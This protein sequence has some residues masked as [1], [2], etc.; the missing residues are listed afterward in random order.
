MNKIK[1][2]IFIFFLFASS[3][4]FSQSG[5]TVFNDT[6]LHEIRIQF[7]YS[8]WFDSLQAD[9]QLNLNDTSDEFSNRE[10]LCSM[11]FDNILLDSIGMR[12]RGNFSNFSAPLTSSNGLKKPF[13]LI[14][15]AFQTQKFD[16]LKELNLN[17]GTDDPSFV[18]EALVY[19]LVRDRGLP[20]CRTGYAKLFVNDV[21]WGLYELVENVDKTFLKDHY[22]DA[23]NDGNLYKTDRNAGVDL[24]WKGTDPSG[25]K[26]QGLLL[27][28]N[29][30]LNDWS[31][32][33]HFVDIINHTQPGNMEQA[34][35]SVFD[36]EDYLDILAIEVLC[37]SW[38][39][40]WAN[41]NN[42][43]LYE[44]P[45]GK[46][47][48]I[49]WDYNETFTTKG[50][51]L[52]IVLPK[53]SDI[54]LSTHFDRKPLLKAIFSVRKWQDMYLDKICDICTNQY[55]PPLISPTLHKWQSLIRPALV[56]D[57]NALGSMPSFDNSLTIDM[58]NAYNIPGHNSGFNIKVPALLPYISNQREWA[59]NQIKSQ[60]GTCALSNVSPSEY[61]MA[62]YPNPAT[63]F[64]DMAWDQLTTDVY[65]ISVYNSFG[66]N[67][68]RTRWITNDTM[69]EQLN[70]SQLPKGFYIVRKRDADGFWAD[71][72]FIKQ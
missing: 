17:N 67:V 26:K 69:H 58:D 50:G 40:Y 51:I 15:D 68:I 61:S 19:K 41:G 48:W 29:D 8:T 1:N 60:G 44:H 5:G 63:D 14:F 65:Q 66:Q 32:F 70:I 30:S 39:S 33:T 2:S 24:K 21:Y 42:F 28:T 10:F 22:G 52:G 34:L 4:A 47:R 18:R 64:I 72:K 46:I 71:A 57:T 16:G 45:D 27:K 20:A 25:Y 31:N 23:N 55:W 54:F 38:D 36:V 35:S 3:L 53:E 6:I 11:S 62:L 9:Y 37:Y 12:E 13:K 59:V 56:L 49:P 43:Y 7:P